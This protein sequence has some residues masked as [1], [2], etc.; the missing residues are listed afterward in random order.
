MSSSDTV[1]TMRPHLKTAIASRTNPIELPRTL[2]DLR[3]KFGKAEYAESEKLS[4]LAASNA[5]VGQR[6]LCIA[7]IEFL[8]EA[9][10]TQLHECGRTHPILVLYVGA[11]IPAVLTALDLF[12]QDR[13]V[14]FDPSVE[15]TLAVARREL[16]P[17]AEKIIDA[18]MNTVS[19]GLWSP[20]QSARSLRSR[21]ALMFVGRTAGLFED[22]TCDWVLTVAREMGETFELA[23][24]SDIR[25]SIHGPRKELGIA[26]DMVA[27]ARWARTL[28]VKKFCVKF[29]LPFHITADIR[30]EYER[31]MRTAVTGL[32]VPYMH[33]RCVLQK[34]ARDFSTEMR[35]I[36]LK[37]T[38]TTHYDI[39]DVEKVLAP[40]NVVHR[41]HTRYS[42]YRAPI[43]HGDERVPIK[44]VDQVAESIAESIY[45]RETN[46]TRTFDTMGEACVLRDAVL[47][48][49][50]DAKTYADACARFAS[51]FSVRTER[52]LHKDANMG[53]GRAR[54]TYASWVL[55]GPIKPAAIKAA[56]VVIRGGGDGDMRSCVG[57]I[58]V[59]TAISVAA[60]TAVASTN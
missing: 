39:Q 12:P 21:P 35:L 22:S 20:K 6:K 34:Y 24:V 14:C 3:R 41:G 1:P 13:F 25:R 59:C 23:F 46:A 44:L 57:V 50:G 4:E 31:G 52:R 9:H 40:F 38:S 49:G 17:E 33:G 53:R 43:R 45:S 32:N 55:Q 28:R 11:S 36:G 2:D 26:E 51:M 42:P 56:P 54:R 5:H 15:M 47:I 48:T 58:G 27:Q 19:T 8:V 10:L 37:G 18:R 7:M 29:R 16:G 30:K 60:A